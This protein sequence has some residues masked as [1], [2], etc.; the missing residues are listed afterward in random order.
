MSPN[1]RPLLVA[2]A[3]LA[4]CG[5]KKSNGCDPVARTGC[6]AGLV[7]EAVVG[8]SG[9]ACFEPLLVTGTVYDLAAGKTTGA[10]PGARVVAVDVNGAPVAP[11]TLSAA[12]TGA[13]SIEVPAPRS[14]DGT[15][16]DTDVTLRADARGFQPFP[17]GV[18][19]AVPVSLASATHRDGRW[20][21]AS[22]LTD[23]GLLAL[24]QAEADLR[25]AALHGSVTVPPDRAGVLVVAETGSPAKGTTAVASA[26]GTYALLNLAPGD[27]TVKAY[28]RGSQYESKAVTLAASEDAALDLART[29]AAVAGVNGQVKLVGSMPAGE[30]F[31]TSVI[32]VLKSTF[33]DLA[34]S[35]QTLGRGDAVPGLRAPG[36]GAAPSV[37][38]SYAIPGVPDGEYVALA[39]YENDGVVRQISG[40]GGTA[41]V[42][43]TVANG[44]V[45]GDQV[46]GGLVDE[47]KMVAAVPLY[48]PGGDAPEDVTGPVTFEWGDVSPTP[49]FYRVRLFDASGAESWSADLDPKV[50]GLCSS[51]RCSTAYPTSAPALQDGLPYQLRV[52]AWGTNSSLDV[53]TSH[54][55]DLRGIFT[56]HAPAP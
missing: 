15:P 43:L 35:G 16:A 23:V 50:G 52:E 42:F 49:T 27:Y 29:G 11:V 1:V 26:D 39:G 17:G 38:S 56:W 46:A 36:G 30:T 5:G 31:H 54:T 19:V 3:L 25:S 2:A 32:L 48:G 41:P 24:S 28:A 34:G 8:Q 14:A 18:R 40:Q 6:D 55:E 4:A 22:P 21:V 44:V 47:F 10:I 37:T 7:C 12:D 20:T 33:D 9:G 45:T 13:W 53:I 51:D